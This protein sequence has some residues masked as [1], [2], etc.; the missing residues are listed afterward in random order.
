MKKPIKKCPAKK[1]IKKKAFDGSARTSMPGW[2]DVSKDFGHGAIVQVK[3]HGP[4][5]HIDVRLPADRPKGSM[6]FYVQG[7]V[8]D[9]VKWLLANKNKLKYAVNLS[10]EA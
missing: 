9:A 10:T 2:R 1:P 8:E 5:A 7:T 4:N 3:R 6:T